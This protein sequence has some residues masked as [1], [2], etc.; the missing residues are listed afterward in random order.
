MYAGARCSDGGARNLSATISQLFSLCVGCSGQNL[1]L[2][3][4]DGYKKLKIHIASGLANSHRLPLFSSN[5]SKIPLLNY[6]SLAW[7][8]CTSLKSH[9]F[10]ENTMK[11]NPIAVITV[12]EKGCWAG[13]T[14]RSH[15]C[16]LSLKDCPL[17]SHI[18]EEHDLL[19]K[20]IRGLLEFEL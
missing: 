14:R 20:R 7:I 1:L 15:Y 8:A 9:C 6:I 3:G 17:P 13:R 4:Q 11:G 12:K 10:R 16:L 2:R 5:P 19:S 18:L